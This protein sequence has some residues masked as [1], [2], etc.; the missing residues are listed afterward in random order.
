MDAAVTQAVG[1]VVAVGMVLSP[2]VFAAVSA[3]RGMLGA[4]SP[5]RVI[6]PIA[7][8]V[9]GWLFAALVLVYLEYNLDRRSVGMTLLAGFWAYAV[10]AGLNAQGKT[11]RA[12]R[13][14]PVEGAGRG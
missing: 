6:L 2:F 10:S 12:E 11:A 3:L 1:L 7:G 13:P 14:P 9:L 5:R 4:H 8:V